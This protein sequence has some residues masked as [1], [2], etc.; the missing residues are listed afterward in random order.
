MHTA[1]GWTIYGKDDG[2][3][4]VEDIPRVMVNF[5]HQM[6]PS[7]D[8]CNDILKILEQDF[9]DLDLPQ[10]T[11]MLLEDKRALQIMNQ[12]VKK[13]GDHYSVGLQWKD[14]NLQ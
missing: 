2:N 9:A 5:V 14:D 4:E 12:T 6:K 7:R 10:V 8:L 13:I 11:C 1:L 3:Q